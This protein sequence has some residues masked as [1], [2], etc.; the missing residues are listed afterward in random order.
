V[1]KRPRALCEPARHHR[2]AGNATSLHRRTHDR[3]TEWRQGHRLQHRGGLLALQQVEACPQDPTLRS[4]LSCSCSATSR[5]WTMARVPKSPQSSGG[6]FTIAIRYHL[7]S[8]SVTHPS[9]DARAGSAVLLV[10]YLHAEAD[11]SPNF[12]AG[13]RADRHDAGTGTYRLGSD[14]RP[15]KEDEGSQPRETACHDTRLP[16]HSS[17]LGTRS[18]S[19]A[20]EMK[21]SRTS[22]A[23]SC[24]A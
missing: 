15:A 24:F 7:R 16:P 6:S 13:P 14:R 11:Q 4:P 9:A 18:R 17:R 19:H 3:S 1:R 12:A 20:T 22:P 23:Q 10:A 8:P 2:S 21:G 5:G